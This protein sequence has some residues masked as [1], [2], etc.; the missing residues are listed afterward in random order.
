MVVIVTRD[1]YYGSWRNESRTR[2]RAKKTSHSTLSLHYDET[3][4][5]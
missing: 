1:S 4:S 2:S 3:K 5:K